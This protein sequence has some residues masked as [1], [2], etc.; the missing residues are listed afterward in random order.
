MTIPT[1]VVVGIILNADRQVLISYR[2]P[3]SH[4]GGLW[5]FPGGKL[6]S[7][8]SAVEG[9]K[10]EF[11]EE[12]GIYPK[13]CFPLS[14]IFKFCSMFFMPCM[15]RCFSYNIKKLF[16]VSSNYSSKS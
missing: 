12:L 8:E 1:H 14:N 10:R 9:L 2:H 11:S 5:E 13:R 7:G 6:E 16:Y 3:G 4:Q 15:H